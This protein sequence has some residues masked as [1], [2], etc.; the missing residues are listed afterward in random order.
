[1]AAHY[2]KYQRAHAQVAQIVAV[3]HVDFQ[4]AVAADLP[5]VGQLATLKVLAHQH[6]E[7]GRLQRADALVAS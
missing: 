1:M 2:L 4:Y 5:Y 7:V 3:F 6:T